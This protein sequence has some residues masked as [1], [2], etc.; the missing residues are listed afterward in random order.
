M[1]QFGVREGD[2]AAFCRVG[3]ATT[4]SQR[5]PPPPQFDPVQS[6]Q[7]LILVELFGCWNQYANTVLLPKTGEQPDTGLIPDGDEW[8]KLVSHYCL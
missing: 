5:I 2:A 1:G 6:F 8:S 3:A 4:H 7:P